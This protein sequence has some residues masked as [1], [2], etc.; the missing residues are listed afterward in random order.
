VGYPGRPVGDLWAADPH[1]W[2]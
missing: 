2:G 1:T